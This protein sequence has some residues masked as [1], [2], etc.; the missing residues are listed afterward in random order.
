MTVESALFL[1]GEEES[2]IKNVSIEKMHLI[3]KKQGTQ[4][5]NVFDEQPSV[6]G[7]YPHSIPVVYA[8]CV[9][10]LEIDGTVTLEGAYQNCSLQEIEG[11]KEVQICLKKQ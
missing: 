2:R 8:R 4:N 1:A 10:Y 11:C 3:M 9:D 5:A 6:R 7:V